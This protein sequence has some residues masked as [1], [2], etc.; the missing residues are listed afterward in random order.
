MNTQKAKNI[1]GSDLELCCTDPVTGFFRDGFC[2]TNLVDLGTHVI[3]AVVT[4]E[5]LDYT[6]SKG[7]DLSSPAPQYD[8]PG[9]KEGD[10]WCL[11][12]LRWKEA[13]EAGVAPPIKPKSTHEKCLEIIDKDILEKYYIN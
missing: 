13:H 6:K 3:C 12:A 1:L 4:Q 11:C 2:N 5:F 7:N 9:L 10:G 8:F